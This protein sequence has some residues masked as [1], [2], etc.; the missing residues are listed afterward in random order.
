MVN[1]YHLSLRS[2]D[3]ILNPH[4]HLLNPHQTPSKWMQVPV[5]LYGPLIDAHFF[6]APAQTAA[7]ERT[8]E[9]E[10]LGTMEL[11]M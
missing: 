10:M 1:P 6:V 8:Q 3:L 2:F 5:G 11:F 4:D 7:R 9:V